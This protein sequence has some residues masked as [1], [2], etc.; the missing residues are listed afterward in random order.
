[1]RDGRGAD[2]HLTLGGT[3][4]AKDGMARFVFAKRTKAHGLELG[5]EMG[6]NTWA[7]TSLPS[8]RI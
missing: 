6:V 8:T 4:Q 2:R 5:S 1:M 7:A 3:A